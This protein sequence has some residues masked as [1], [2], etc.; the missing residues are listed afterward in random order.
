MRQL[1]WKEDLN[2]TCPHCGDVAD[3]TFYLN[4][5]TLICD[6]CDKEFDIVL[7]VDNIKVVST[8]M[9]V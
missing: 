2:A 9:E 1:Y 3:H 4:S 7:Y 6:K 5:D 8:K